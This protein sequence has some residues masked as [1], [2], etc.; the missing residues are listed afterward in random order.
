MDIGKMISN[1]I[2]VLT[3]P[4]Q[5]F[6]RLKKEQMTMQTIIIYVAIFALP[7][8]IGYIVGYGVVGVSYSYAFVS[9]SYK[10]PIANAVGFGIFYYIM[11]IILVI[12]FG[13]VINMLA[14]SFKSRQDL[15]QSMKL[16]A[17]ASTPS[18]IA[19]IFNIWPPIALL[20]LLF[21]IYGIYL[22]YIGIPIFMDTP[23]DQHII[24]LIICIIV[25]IVFTF[26]I[27]WVVSSVM[28]TSVGG[29]GSWAP[30]YRPF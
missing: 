10:V 2:S 24:Y 30:Y 23:Q 5:A 1:G 8:L 25:L 22:L 21:A 3:G 28:W 13:Y 18:L 14:P 4:K 20:T 29:Y 19:G 17:F 15:I 16:A 26:I 11:W 9:W 27:S 6:Q 7:G 12:V